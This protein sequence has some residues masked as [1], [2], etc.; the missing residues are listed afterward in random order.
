M[1]KERAFMTASLYETYLIGSK[2][3]YFF[4]GA[5]IGGII[6]MILFFVGRRFLIGVGCLLV[7]GLLSFIH[8]VASIV[9]GI[10]LL[11]CAL[12]VIVPELKEKAEKKRKAEL[13]AEKK[14]RIEENRKKREKEKQEK[15]SAAKK[16]NADPADKPNTPNKNKKTNK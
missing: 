4:A 2:I 14:K 11:I 16:Q 12:I 5:F 7:C 1:I 3:G 9:G 8:P 15:L 6:P 10:V 13:K